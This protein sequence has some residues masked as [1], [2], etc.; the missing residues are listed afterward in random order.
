[1]ASAELW[2]NV[3]ASVGR[4][5]SVV[6]KQDGRSKDISLIVIHTILSA[7]TISKYDV[8]MKKV[9]VNGEQWRVWRE[10]VLSSARNT[11]F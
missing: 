8:F 6:L 4:P 10:S 9:R 2:L 7:L 5:H 3:A 1:M 11:R